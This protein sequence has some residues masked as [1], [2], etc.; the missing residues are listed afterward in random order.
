MD[1]TFRD[2]HFEIVHYKD[3]TA[4]GICEVLES[5]RKKDHKNKDCF[6]CCILTHG[7]KGI[8]YGS[9]GQEASIYELTS[10]FTGLKCPS[11]IG[12][13]KIFF[14]QA[15]Q[16]DKYQK[17]VAVETDSEQMEAYLEVDSS[18]QKRYIPD[19]ADFLLGMATVKDYVSYR[20]IWNGTWYIQ[21]LCQNLRER[22]PR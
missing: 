19:E 22:C 2:L 11:L 10:Y 1:K 15:C 17:G 4:K 12:K 3:Q 16:G 13:P 14:I 8:I 5:Y 21:S 6:I 9:D 7:N 18:P 20:N